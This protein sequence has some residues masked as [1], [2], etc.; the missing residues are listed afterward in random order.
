MPIG[1]IR[2][3]L[4]HHEWSCGS[5]ASTSEIMEAEQIL[6]PFPNDYKKFLA[7][8]G[9]LA[10]GAFEVYGLGKGKPSHVDV[11]RMT[12]LER[13]EPM[14]PL[15]ESWVCVANDGAGNLA[16]FD[17]NH[18]AS[19]SSC[20]ISLWDH[21]LGRDQDSETLAP[22]FSNWLTELLREEETG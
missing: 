6:G 22:S 19:S 16:S 12:L 17:T 20:P 13:S 4:S 2:E 21:E 7:E 5:G 9:W 11:T 14:V 18:A 10:F 8:F 3:L 1:E 15:P